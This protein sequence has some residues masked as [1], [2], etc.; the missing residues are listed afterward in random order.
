M[1]HKLLG[2][3]FVIAAAAAVVSLAIYWEAANQAISPMPIHQVKSGEA[4]PGMEK[5]TN[6]KL[7]FEISYN[8]NYTL[9]TSGRSANFFKNSADTIASISI[10]QTLYPKTNFGSAVVT[11]AVQT[12]SSQAACE[13][14]SQT[15]TVNGVVF[16]ESEQDGAAAG[17]K[18]Q[19][20][21]Y[22]TFHN[23][24]CFEVSLT[25]GISNIQ[26]YEPGA[27]TEVNQ[28]ELSQRLDKI[29]GSFKFTTTETVMCGGFG[30]IKC[31]TEGFNCALEGSFPDAGTICTKQN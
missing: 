6:D 17:T 19:T 8:K 10:P 18:Y 5:Y 9:D 4:A 23:D 14:A 1:K 29:F 13:K 15:Q 21:I 22:R 11:V 25:T 30:G 7:G 26:N 2:F 20:Q 24:S 16:H 31:P 28:N 12:A 27:V 3:L